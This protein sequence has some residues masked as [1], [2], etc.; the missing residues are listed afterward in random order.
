MVRSDGRHDF[1]GDLLIDLLEPRLR[2]N[3]GF[4]SQFRKEQERAV[5]NR[6]PVT[7]WEAQVAAKGL[8]GAKDADWNDGFDMAR[9][10]PKNPP[11]KPWTLQPTNPELL[12]ALANDFSDCFTT[13]PDFRPYMCVPVDSR[14][15][16]PEKAKDPKDPDYG[17][18][19]KLPS[20]ALDDPDEM[21]KVLR[22]GEKEAKPR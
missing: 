17:K 14:I 7:S 16:D 3:P 2:A 20:M 15:F 12:D 9:L 22:R 13:K 5:L 6:D 11:P 10:D 21:E 19:R 18:A 4:R 8:V 1:V